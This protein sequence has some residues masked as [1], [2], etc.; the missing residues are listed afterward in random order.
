MM[1]NLRV[2][3]CEGNRRARLSVHQP[4]QSGLA[5]DDTVW[6][7]HL[8]A[9]SWQ[10]NNELGREIQEEIDTTAAQANKHHKAGTVHCSSHIVLLK[11]SAQG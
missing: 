2:D 5:L 10:E 7:T 6:D 1:C 9:E 3:L 4:A 8:A 11:V